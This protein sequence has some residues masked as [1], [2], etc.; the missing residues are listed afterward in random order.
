MTARLSMLLMNYFEAHATHC[1]V[2]TATA[3]SN[4]TQIWGAQAFRS[5]WRNRDDIGSR[6]QDGVIE[7]NDDVAEPKKPI[8]L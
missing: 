3:A 4:S 5:S 2:S 7:W 6:G 8:T 1:F